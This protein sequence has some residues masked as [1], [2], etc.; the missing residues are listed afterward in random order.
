LSV[1]SFRGL[2]LTYEGLAADSEVG[3]TETGSDG[4]DNKIATFHIGSVNLIRNL[5]KRHLR[6]RP[7]LKIK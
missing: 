2:G 1:I 4:L 7:G 5:K 3:G 6:L